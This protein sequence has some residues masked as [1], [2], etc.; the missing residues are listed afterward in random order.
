LTKA[1]G[2]H[3]I[4]QGNVKRH[5]HKRE[6][7]A[8]VS[9][10]QRIVSIPSLDRQTQLNEGR[11][12]DSSQDL[13]L[14]KII[15]QEVERLRIGCSDHG[16]SHRMI[17]QFKVSGWIRDAHLVPNPLNGVVTLLSKRRERPALRDDSYYFVGQVYYRSRRRG[18]FRAPE[19]VAQKRS[20]PRL[21]AIQ[22]NSDPWFAGHQ[23]SRTCGSPLEGQRTAGRQKLELGLH[24]GTLDKLKSA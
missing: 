17:R 4:E 2:E 12:G 14:H 11:P 18:L 20:D 5:R 3:L 13:P 16:C 19:P 21:Q 6:V 7:T 22:N 24:D 9:V 1:L 10:L 15:E 8:R 23:S